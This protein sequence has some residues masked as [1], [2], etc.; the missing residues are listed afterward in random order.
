V[1]GDCHL[2]IVGSDIVGAER[3][4]LLDEVRAHRPVVAVLCL[5]DDSGGREP[6]GRVPVLEEPFTAEQL[7]A[8]VRQ[9]LPELRGGSVL[10]LR[11]EAL[12]P[13]AGLV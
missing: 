2:V 13:P 7:R 6:R 8:A 1:A 12:T 4:E 9:L 5:T 3:T 10:A 11:V